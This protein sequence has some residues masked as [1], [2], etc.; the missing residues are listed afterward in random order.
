MEELEK[1]IE[2][3]VDFIQGYYTAKPNP[4]V[5]DRIDANVKEEIVR[6]ANKYMK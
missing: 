3:D 1:V 5:L 6:F 4:V 2:L